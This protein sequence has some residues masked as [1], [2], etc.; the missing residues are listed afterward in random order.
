MSKNFGLPKTT[1]GI[2]A[3]TGFS[4]DSKRSVEYKTLIT[5]EMLAKGYLA[6]TSIYACIEHSEEIVKNYFDALEPIFALVGECEKGK[7]INTLLKGPVCHSSFK[8]LT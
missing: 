3:F 7:D 8:R 5:Q 4:F 6:G 1:N 2:P